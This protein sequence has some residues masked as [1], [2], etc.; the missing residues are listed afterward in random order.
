MLAAFQPLDPAATYRV[1]ATDF[2]A[3]IAPGYSDL[4]KQAAASPIPASSSTT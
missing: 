2:Q 3:K 4:F 1:A